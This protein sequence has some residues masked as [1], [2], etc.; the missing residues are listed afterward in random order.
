MKTV[1]LFTLLFSCIVLFSSCL[2][3]GGEVVTVVYT[4]DQLKTLQQ[5]LNVDDKLIDYS[6]NLPAHIANQGAST[7]TIDNHKALLGRVLFYDNKLSKND[8]VNCSSCHLQE[9]A[10]SDDVA[11]SKGFDDE[12]TKRNS[13]ALGAVVSFEASYENPIGPRSQF[14]WD[15]RASTIQE[16]SSL[17]I[18]DKN[19]PPTR[20]VLILV[21]I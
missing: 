15:E 14:F 10:F 8:A 1:N 17:T 4:Q 5:S 11:F 13:L 9:K 19:T 16:Q 12:H 7:S 2:T 20:A 18:Q 3:D 6:I 21:S